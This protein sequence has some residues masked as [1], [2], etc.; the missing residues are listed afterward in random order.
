MA[1]V[2]WCGRP[3]ARA[4]SPQAAKRRR[5]SRRDS[6]SGSCAET[7]SVT[8]QEK[9]AFDIHPRDELLSSGAVALPMDFRLNVAAR[10][11]GGL[12][13]QI[14]CGTSLYTFAPKTR[15]RGPASSRSRPKATSPSPRSSFRRPGSSR[16][17][18]SS[19]RGSPTRW[20]GRSGV[21]TSPGFQAFCNVPTLSL[22]TTVSASCSPRS[23]TSPLSDPSCMTLS[24]MTELANRRTTIE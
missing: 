10:A 14:V 5:R 12:R 13:V 9:N 18:S 4:A 1:R 22:M 6:K 2:R 7:G 24:L 20:S 15:A 19:S 21:A 17:S 3:G 16:R 23:T 11:L 8:A